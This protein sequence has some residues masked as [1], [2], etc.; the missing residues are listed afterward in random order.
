MESIPPRNQTFEQRKEDLINF[1]NKT[2]V[3]NVLKRIC[4]DW[5]NRAIRENRKR[6]REHEERMQAQNQQ[7]STRDCM[8]SHCTRSK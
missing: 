6:K 4:D 1:K 5:E 8:W 2:K 7:V 3:T